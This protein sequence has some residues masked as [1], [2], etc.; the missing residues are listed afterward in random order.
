MATTSQPAP[1]PSPYPS[2]AGKRRLRGE[3]GL[4][5]IL[6]FSPQTMLDMVRYF[7]QTRFLP[8]PGRSCQGEPE[9]RMMEGKGSSK[10]IPL[11]RSRAPQRLPKKGFALFERSE[12]AKP[13]QHRG[14]QGIPPSAGQGTRVPFSCFFFWARKRRKREQQ[15]KAAG[16]SPHRPKLHSLS[17]SQPAAINRSISSLPM[18]SF[19][20]N[21]LA[22]ASMM[23][24]FSVSSR[25]AVSLAS[26][27]SPVTAWSI[28]T[29]VSPL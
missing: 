1:S 3:R 29:A 22:M 5:C 10:K 7:F 24:R 12:F 2:P 4:S 6:R 18:V 23:G 11:A 16:V 17:V 15:K 27:T 9:G 13:R 21:A 8:L 19:S 14:A 28:L 26:A 25:V 20:S